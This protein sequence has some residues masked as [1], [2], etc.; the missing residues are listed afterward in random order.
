M[1]PHARSATPDEI[2]AKAGTQDDSTTP[3]AIAGVLR[4]CER[5]RYGGPAQ[6]PSHELLI[7]ALDQAEAVLVSGRDPGR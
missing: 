2:D 7:R 4:E 3:R 5:V 1:N 6:S